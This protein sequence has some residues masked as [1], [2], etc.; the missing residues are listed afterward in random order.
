MLNPRGIQLFKPRELSI[1]LIDRC[2]H[3]SLFRHDG[4]GYFREWANTLCET[5]TNLDSLGFQYCE[6]VWCGA[7]S[8]DHRTGFLTMVQKEYWNSLAPKMLRKIDDQHDP[9]SLQHRRIM[10]AG[11]D[12]EADALHFQESQKSQ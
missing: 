12:D 8:E 1:I 5:F 9:D 3:G 6:D 10:P 2:G 7:L 4:H 11:R